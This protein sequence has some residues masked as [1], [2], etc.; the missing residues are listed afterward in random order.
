VHAEARGKVRDPRRR[1]ETRRDE[2]YN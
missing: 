2:S 1:D